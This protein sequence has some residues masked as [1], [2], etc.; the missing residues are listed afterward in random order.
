MLLSEFVPD[1]YKTPGAL[2]ALHQLT[3]R[4]QETGAKEDLAQL[5]D[6][7]STLLTAT[8]AE[9]QA[10]PREE[11]DKIFQSCLADWYEDVGRVY[12]D[13]ITCWGDDIDAPPPPDSEDVMSNDD[14]VSNPMPGIF[15]IEGLPFVLS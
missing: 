4:A 6:A 7:V 1:I 11:V 13:M 15:V 14:L 5:A 3:T 9:L 2:A 12:D 8:A 10:T